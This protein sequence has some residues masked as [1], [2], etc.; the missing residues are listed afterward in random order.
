MSATQS[1]LSALMEDVRR[2]GGPW[3]VPQD[4]GVDPL[5]V[6]AAWLASADPFAML[7]LLAAIHP[8]HNEPVC[9]AL[10]ASMSFFR[11]MKREGEKQASSRGG[12][13]YNGP[14]RFRFT[15]LAQRIR[16]GVS[17]LSAADRS[18]VEPQLSAAIRAMVPDPHSLAR[19]V[20]SVPRG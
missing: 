20:L 14:D 13:N 19:E 2:R 16:N 7:L 12:M 1:T 9:E 11:P 10:V 3:S 15:H 6:T 8:H 18:R 4:L 5:D 17:E